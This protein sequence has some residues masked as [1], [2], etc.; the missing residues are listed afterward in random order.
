MS[1]VPAAFALVAV[2]VM[3]LYNLDAKALARMGAELAA[4]KAAP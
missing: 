4:R 1:F 2:L 3:C